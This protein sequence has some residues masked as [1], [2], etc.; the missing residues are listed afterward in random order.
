MIN[1]RM[2]PPTAR[3]DAVAVLLHAYTINWF[4]RHYDVSPEAVPTKRHTMLR[5]Q[6]R[7]TGNRAGLLALTPP[8][9]LMPDVGCI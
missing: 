9:P 4:H 3:L 7:Q 2:N 1:H 8:V 6:S 5:G